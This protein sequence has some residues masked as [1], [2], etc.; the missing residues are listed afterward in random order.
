M[1][2]EYGNYEKYDKNTIEQE[3]DRGED[4]IGRDKF[5][6]NTLGMHRRVTSLE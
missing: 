1:T 5:S 2:K 4:D 6:K 3:I